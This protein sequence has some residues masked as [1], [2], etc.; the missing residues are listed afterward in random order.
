MDCR[1]PAD[2]AMTTFFTLRM[3][4]LLAPHPYRHHECAEALAKACVVIQG[5]IG[6]SLCVLDCRASF[7]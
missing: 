3:F 1:G 2:L 6:I 4:L 5:A 7:R